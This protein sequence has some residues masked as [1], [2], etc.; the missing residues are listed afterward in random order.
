[1]ANEFGWLSKK[2]YALKCDVLTGGFS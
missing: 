2:T 1:M